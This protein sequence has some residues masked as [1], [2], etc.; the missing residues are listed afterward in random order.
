[1]SPPF[2][3]FLSFIWIHL[4]Y[5]MYFM[6]IYMT[7]LNPKQKNKMKSKITST[8][9]ISLFIM[10]LLVFGYLI[11]FKL[12]N[13]PNSACDCET[14]KYFTVGSSRIYRLNQKN[15]CVYRYIIRSK[16]YEDC[17]Y[18]GSSCASYLENKGINCNS[19][20]CGTKTIDQINNE[21]KNFTDANSE[22][23]EAMKAGDYDKAN[24]AIIKINDSKLSYP[25]ADDIKE[26]I[27]TTGYNSYMK[28]KGCIN[29]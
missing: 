23:I 16:N 19:I 6:L 20:N 29:S 15:R 27:K 17:S 28:L 4:F 21:I 25:S 1:V 11:H 10:S 3:I 5:T 13:Y 22:Y 26:Q 8:R 12:S 7:Q 18:L 9:I 14:A 24:Q 2:F